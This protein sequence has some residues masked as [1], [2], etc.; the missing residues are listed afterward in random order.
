MESQQ[1]RRLKE[2]SYNAIQEQQSRESLH[3]KS[4]HDYASSSNHYDPKSNIERGSFKR[5]TQP[6]ETRL[7][8]MLFLF[9]FIRLKE[10]ILFCQPP[11]SVV[12]RCEFQTR[13]ASGPET[14]PSATVSQHLLLPPAT[15]PIITHTAATPQGSPNATLDSICSH[16]DSVSCVRLSPLK[17]VKLVGISAG[18]TSVEASPLHGDSGITLVSTTEASKSLLTYRFLNLNKRSNRKLTLICIRRGWRL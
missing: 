10:T 14:H 11:P 6:I 13:T 7:E 2:N 8:I 3:S 1:Q 17:S 4:Q 5:S 12:S 18:R 9:L 16:R 15:A